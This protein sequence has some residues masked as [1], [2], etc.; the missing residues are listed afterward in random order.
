MLCS[1]CGGE[2]FF[3]GRIGTVD[4]FRCRACGIVSQM[5]A[6]EELSEETEELPDDATPKAIIIHEN[7]DYWVKRERKA[8]TVYKN[9]LTHATSDS[10]YAKTDD[11]R[12]LAI[13]RCNYLAN[14]GAK[15]KS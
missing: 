5:I 9:G 15:K 11:G 4:N 13:A 10:A 12:S 6:L 14:R 2:V 3:L 1:Y 8:Y 7:D